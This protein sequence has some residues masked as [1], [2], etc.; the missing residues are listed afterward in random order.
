MKHYIE[1][2]LLHSVEIPLYFLWEKVYQQVHLAFVEAQDNNEKVD[3]GAAFPDYDAKRFYLGNRLRLFAQDES[4][5]KKLDINKWLSRFLDYVH[6]SGVRGVPD[7]V[8][9]HA[10]FKRLQTKSS[11][12]RLARR[13]AKREKISY[14]EALSAL[15]KREEETSN[16][17]YIH[18]KSLSSDKCYRLMIDCVSHEQSVSGKFSTY[19]LSSTSTVPVF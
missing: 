18:V 15:R 19:G 7:D 1:L 4:K 11:N 16:A 3:I 2:S 17:P 5:L 8:L 10:C 12:E 14:E 9:G 13:K 6:I